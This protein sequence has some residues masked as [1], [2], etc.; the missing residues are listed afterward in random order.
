M[1]DKFRSVLVLVIVQTMVLSLW[2]VSAAIIADLKQ[3]EIS[4]FAR[5]ALSSSVQAGF[6]LGALLVAVSGI[7]DKWDPR[8]VL[9][10]S[11][12]AAALSSIALLFVAPGSTSAIG[13]R[14]ATGLF[15]AGVYPVG[16]KIA[17]GWGVADR[18][19]LVG[20]LVGGLTIGSASSHLVAYFGGADWRLTIMVASGLAMLGA[21]MMS[22][23]RL[24]PHHRAARSFSAQAVR[25]VWQDRRIQAAYGGYLGH[26]WELYA[27]W[28]WLSV[29]LTASFA[30]Q[31]DDAGQFAKLVTFIA[32][33]VGGI[34]SAVAGKLA[35]RIGKARLAIL[36]ML[37]SLI[38][39]LAFAVCFGGPVLLVSAIAIFWGLVIVPDSAQFS[40]LIA[41]FSP[42]EQ[43]GSIMTLQTALGFA[44]TAVTV[45]LAPVV[46]DYCGWPIVMAALALGPLFGII[47]MRRLWKLEG[48]N[49]TPAR[50]L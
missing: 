23:V 17:V 31:V 2:F 32:I 42:P 10:V 49:Q 18:G 4:A 47:S 25:V 48:T 22:L 35:D 8:L 20:L 5:A 45:Q 36:A 19:F 39:A 43:A 26:M 34:A 21:A 11:A 14:F 1:S 46:A 3:Y 44:L 38:S 15:L 37:L 16:M 7:A 41:D 50:T 29:A 9:G 13:F 40:A 24:G 33:A 30:N 28:A 12:L 27:M 6:V